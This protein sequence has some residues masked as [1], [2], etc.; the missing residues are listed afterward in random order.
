MPG[1]ACRGLLPTPGPGKG[2]DRPEGPRAS[3]SPDVAPSRLAQGRQASAAPGLSRA[4]RLAGAAVGVTLLM[5]VNV[6]YV[7]VHTR[8]CV[9][10]SQGVTHASV[11]VCVHAHTSGLPVGA[12][13]ACVVKGRGALWGPRGAGSRRPGTAPARARG[14]VVP[15]TSRGPAL[16]LPSPNLCSPEASAKGWRDKLSSFGLCGSLRGLPPNLVRRIQPLCS[17]PPQAPSRPPF[18]PLP[19]TSTGQRG[20]GG[21]G[22][23][24]WGG[25]R[26]GLC[27]SGPGCPRALLGTAAVR[28][29]PRLCGR[30]SGVVLRLLSVASPEDL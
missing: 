11:C 6:T 13:Q 3:S 18:R 22:R 23:R 7:R 27:G 29:H 10:Y 9:L 14:S 15:E 19:A 25:P 21:G 26:V 30:G 2:Q 5:Y 24:G 4:S 20:R 12:A 17:W 16:F 28:V 1:Q 8:V